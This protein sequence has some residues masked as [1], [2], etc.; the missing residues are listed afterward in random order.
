[1]EILAGAVQINQL[2]DTVYSTQPIISLIALHDLL[3]GHNY[4]DV[5]SFCLSVSDIVVAGKKEPVL[6]W[7][8]SFLGNDLQPL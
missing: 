8:S 1:M 3:S 6:G 4:R 7:L 2:G 5:L